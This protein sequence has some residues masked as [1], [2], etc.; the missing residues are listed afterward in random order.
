MGTWVRLACLAP[1]P[2][3]S[4]RTAWALGPGV[5]VRTMWSDPTRGSQAPLTTR[6][7]RTALPRTGLAAH[8]EAQWAL[9]R[10]PLTQAGIAF[11]GE[12]GGQWKGW[13]LR[14][15]ASPLHTQLRWTAQP[16]Q[17]PKSEASWLS[18]EVRT[19]RGGGVSPR[20]P[21]LPG[22]QPYCRS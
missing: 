2:T 17:A 11:W 8:F 9:G 1:R 5:G 10:Q 7:G 18:G 4:H 19:A 14:A 22:G 3:P 13:G 21:A 15:V 12:G 16:P 6:V 20:H